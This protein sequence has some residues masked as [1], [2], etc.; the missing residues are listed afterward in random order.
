MGR[1]IADDIRA[2]EDIDNPGN[3]TRRDKRRDQGNKDVGQL[4]QRIAHRGFVFG[5]GLRFVAIHIA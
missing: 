2:F 4:A 1:K 5:F 3:Q